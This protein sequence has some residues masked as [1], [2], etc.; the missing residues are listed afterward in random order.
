MFSLVWKPKSHL[1]FIKRYIK[2]GRVILA[3]TTHNIHGSR[4]DG[5]LRTIVGHK[6]VLLRA[7]D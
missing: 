5:D 1:S 6:I 2:E 7:W 4:N 3:K